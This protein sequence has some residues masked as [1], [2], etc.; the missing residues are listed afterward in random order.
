MFLFYGLFGNVCAGTQEKAI[1]YE[2][3]MVKVVADNKEYL[4]DA[5]VLKSV[6]LH[7]KDESPKSLMDKV[8]NFGKY[9][10][11]SIAYN[12]A[13]TKKLFFEKNDQAQSVYDKITKD[14][15]L[16]EAVKIP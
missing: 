5:S 12:T 6:S 1:G 11:V 7:K 9:P 4:I 2:K 3:C 13:G 16:C 15:S 8:L 14:L 10:V